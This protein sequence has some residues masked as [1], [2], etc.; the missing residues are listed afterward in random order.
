M[1]RNKVGLAILL[2][3]VFSNYAFALEGNNECF[4][5]HFQIE[6]PQGTAILNL[7]FLAKKKGRSVMQTSETSFD[8][9]DL[10]GCDSSWYLS[11]LM[12]DVGTDA[13]H[14]ASRAMLR[15][16]GDKISFRG[17]PDV[18]FTLSKV[19]EISRTDYKLTYK[20]LP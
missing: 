8:V 1:I 10:S 3:M 14:H 16:L 17:G 13:Q 9:M 7:K 11:A 15:Y 19:D 6:G 4:P 5:K 20:N 2:S 18:N 12:L